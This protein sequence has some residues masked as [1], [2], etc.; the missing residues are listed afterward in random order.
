MIEGA[1][2]SIQALI[3]CGFVNEMVIWTQTSINT[4]ELIRVEDATCF[5]K[6]AQ[7]SAIQLA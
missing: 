2:S 3:A 7:V 4:I 5:M 6:I 1:Y